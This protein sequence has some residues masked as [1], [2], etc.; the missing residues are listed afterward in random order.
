VDNKK[1]KILRKT[2]MVA[3]GRIAEMFSNGDELA[4]E[5]AQVIC[6][7]RLNTAKAIDLINKYRISNGEALNKN[8]IQGTLKKIINV[9]RNSCLDVWE[10]NLLMA[11]LEVITI[12]DLM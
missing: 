9:I 2:I 7:E 3:L 1:H 11:E 8:K 10:V 12:K 5:L 4:L 6:R